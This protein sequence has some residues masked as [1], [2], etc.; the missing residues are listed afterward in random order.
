MILKLFFTA[1]L[2]LFS[3]ITWKLLKLYLRR[4]NFFKLLTKS[5]TKNFTIYPLN[6]GLGQ[7][8]EF[9]NLQHH[10]YIDWSES[11]YKSNDN[12]I[13]NYMFDPMLLTSD[14]EIIKQITITKRLP[15]ASVVYDLLKPIFGNGILLSSGE[16]WKKQR[17]LINPIFS[18][19]NVS[20]LIGVMESN[21]NDSI[22]NWKKQGKI[23]LST[24]MS[25]LTLKIIS[26][27]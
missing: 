20:K 24:E 13:L 1:I 15:K 11:C 17:T 21:T 3:Y 16:L 6:Y 12:V 19:Q 10:H 23:D 27:S 18:H 25:T 14:P 4:L 2:F 9:L 26:E 7:M 5:K 8:P 22:S